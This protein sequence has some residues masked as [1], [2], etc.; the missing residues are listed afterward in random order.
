[1]HPAARPPVYEHTS[2]LTLDEAADHAARRRAP[3]HAWCVIDGRPVDVFFHAELVIHLDVLGLASVD[4][5]AM[6]LRQ[7]LR[8]YRIEL[9][10]WP[11]RRTL[12]CAW[13]E[14]RATATRVVDGARAIALREASARLGIFGAQM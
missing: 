11:H 14:L 6:L 5:V 7:P 8:L 3:L 4:A 2:L 10:R 9:L 1:M 12:A 13:T